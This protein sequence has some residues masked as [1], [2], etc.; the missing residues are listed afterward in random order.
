MHYFS[1]SSSGSFVLQLLYWS[2]LDSN[3]FH[4]FLGGSCLC[5]CAVFLTFFFSEAREKHRQTS[6][7]LWIWEKNDDI[8]L[9]AATDC[10]W[11]RNLSCVNGFL[12]HLLWR[13]GK[14]LRDVYNVIV[15]SEFI[16]MFDCG[17]AFELNCFFY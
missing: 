13:C 17:W 16:L 14:S 11:S 3:M 6:L 5:N 1:P 8:L 7:Q 15:S 12:I 4:E 2:T 10:S 9:C